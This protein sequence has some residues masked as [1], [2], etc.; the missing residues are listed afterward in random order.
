V[1][2]GGYPVSDPC[3]YPPRLSTY[4][5]TVSGE[6]VPIHTQPLRSTQESPEIS[7]IPVDELCGYPHLSQVIHIRHKSIHKDLRTGAGKSPNCD[8]RHQ[9]ATANDSGG[10]MS[11]RSRL[12]PVAGRTRSG[13]DP[14]CSSGQVRCEQREL[15]HLGN[16]RVTTADARG[17]DPPGFRPLPRA[18]PRG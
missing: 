13:R 3:R 9:N 7:T 12:A 11:G 6:T 18:T 10:V 8:K 15:R 17:D 4:P 5:P 1:D 2:C 14:R 16:A